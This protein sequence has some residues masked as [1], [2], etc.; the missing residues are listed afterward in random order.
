M[1]NEE[2]TMTEYIQILEYES[3]DIDALIRA[4]NSV[5]LPDGVPKPT[6]VMVVRDRD[7]PGVYATIHRFNS[8]EEALQHSQ[9][10]ATRERMAKL[11]P[12]VKGGP[13]FINLDVL[14]KETP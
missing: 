3:D 10:G 1:T 2:K 4:A 13:R 8:H 7:R 9:T 6:S 11:A 5:P 12:F 14:D